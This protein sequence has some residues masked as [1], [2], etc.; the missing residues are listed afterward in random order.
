MYISGT[1]FAKDAT[2][3]HSYSARGGPLAMGRHG[4]FS[5][6]FG[7]HY[8]LPPPWSQGPSPS[9]VPQLGAFSLGRGHYSNIGSQTSIFG[10]GQQQSGFQ[11][12]SSNI[13][14][15]GQP[16]QSGF[17]L[18]NNSAS[19]AQPQTGFQFGNNS[20]NAGQPQQSGFQFGNN[21]SGSGGQPQQSGFQFGSSASSG[22]R[23][24][25]F[26]NNCPYC[27]TGH[28]KGCPFGC[29][30]ANYTPRS[31]SHPEVMEESSGNFMFVGRVLVGRICR[32]QPKMRRPPNDESDPQKRPCHTAVNS[33]SQPTIYVVFESAQCYPE[34]LIEYSNQV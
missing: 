28:R 17:Q 31:G 22:A 33:T 3:S 25:H 10:A 19:G 7:A 20:A 1:Y 23:P 27:G 34:Y 15:S 18:G 11:F 12:S 29:S 14:S 4:L 16:Q 13:A 24:L 8:G 5:H 30:G 6:H 9:I 2:Y 32:G 26:L 21:N